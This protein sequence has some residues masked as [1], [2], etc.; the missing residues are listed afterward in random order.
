MKHLS[1]S[2]NKIN[3]SNFKTRKG[4]TRMAYLHISSH[5]WAEIVAKALGI[6]LV[7]YT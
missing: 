2:T 3:S 4:K 7:Y 6:M 1:N 5:N